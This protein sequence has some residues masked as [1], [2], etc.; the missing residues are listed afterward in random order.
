M[1]SCVTVFFYDG[2]KSGK[3][4]QLLILNNKLDKQKKV[5]KLSSCVTVFFYDGSKSGKM[6]Q[7]LILT[8]KIIKKVEK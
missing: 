8:D 1:S 7:A 4:D 3:M 2:S 6:D 5:E